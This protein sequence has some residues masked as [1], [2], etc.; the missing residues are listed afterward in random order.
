M[1]NN[2]IWTVQNDTLKFTDLSVLHPEDKVLV[3][4]KNKLIDQKGNVF[5]KM[6][7]FSAKKG[8]YRKVNKEKLTPILENTRHW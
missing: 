3:I 8:L 6:N 5:K 1:K 7:F 4:E 2:I